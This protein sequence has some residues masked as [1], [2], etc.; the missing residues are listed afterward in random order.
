M[1]EADASTPPLVALIAGG[2]AGGTEGLIT[3]PFEYAKT[4]VQLRGEHNIKNPFTVVGNVY[5]KEGFNA[6]YM[7]CST[8]VAVRTSQQ[9]FGR[10]ILY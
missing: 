2:A 1:K 8:L 4:R 3:Y 7:G 6:L 9:A 5:K 10:W